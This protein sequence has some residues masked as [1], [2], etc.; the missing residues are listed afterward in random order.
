MGCTHTCVVMF[1]C[2]VIND[3][4]PKRPVPQH[5]NNKVGKVILYKTST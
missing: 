4:E 5:K 3:K 2:S 1:P